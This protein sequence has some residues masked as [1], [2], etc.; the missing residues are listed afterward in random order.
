MA[1]RAK[2]WRG[3]AQRT[4]EQD[5]AAVL[6]VLASRPDQWFQRPNVWGELPELTRD[7]LESA[8]TRL[9]MQGK[10][11]QAEGDQ[12]NRRKW[13]AAPQEG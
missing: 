3:N 6:A 10:V 12:S 2:H 4:R 8:L 1:D 13:R 7:R 11:E 9:V 5:E